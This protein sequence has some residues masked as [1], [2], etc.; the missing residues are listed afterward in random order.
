MGKAVKQA[1]FGGL[2][3][4]VSFIPGVGPVF[5]KFLLTLGMSFVTG[6]LAQA[7]APKP[8]RPRPQYD[9]QYSGT[10]EPRAIIYGQ[11]KTSGMNV[12]PHW[13]SGDGN[14]Y[15]HQVIAIAGHEVEDITD[16]YFNQDVI[17]DADIGAITGALD[18]G[19][20]GGSGDY[21]EVAWIRR[22]LGTSGQTADYIL[23]TAFTAWTSNHRGRG[24]AYVATQFEV[25]EDAYKSGQP[26]QSFIV[27]GKK[28]YDPA[29]DTSPGADPTNASYITYTTNPA[30]ILADYLTD[31]NVGCK[32]PTAKIDWDLVL[33][34]A[35]ICDEDVLIPPASP[36]T[37]QKRYTCNVR[38]FVASTPAERRENILLLAGAMMGYCNFQGGKYR[39]YAGAAQSSDYTLTDDDLVGG[40]SVVTELSADKKYNYVPGQFYDASRNYQLLPFEPRSSSTYETNDGGRKEREVEFPACTAQYEAQR[41]AIT[42][43]KRSRRK[44]EISGLWGFSAYKVRPGK[45]G[46]ITL[47]EWGIV[48]QLVRCQS[49][50]MLPNF[51]F[52]VSFIDEL[53]SDWDDPAV[54]DY[55]VPT[56]AVG[57][58]HGDFV[59]AAPQSFAAI[60]VQDGIL[61]QWEPPANATVGTLYTIFE[62]TSATPFSSA[63]A[64]AS[65]LTGTSRTVIKSDTTTRYY[66]ITAKARRFGTDSDPAPAGDGLPAAALAITTGFRLIAD[67]QTH[68]KV[69]IG[70]GTGS[71]DDT[72]TVTPIDAAAA[73]TYTWTRI[74]GS[75]KLEAISASSAT[76]GFRVVAA[77]P[78][79]DQ[80]EVSAVFECEG[81][82]GTDTATLQVTV[83][84]LRDDSFGS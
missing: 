59:P 37:E 24:V 38:I 27:K 23:D 66:W 80:E 28:C 8:K 5:S 40:V 26:Q 51:T 12:I 76:T 74:S 53:A 2:A 17:A 55:T 78:L 81:D 7:L 42:I 41:N 61:F 70:T 32:I 62:Y 14:K 15:L 34:A 1:V 79:S 60:P 43:L 31:T 57:P 67:R 58:T 21:A 54:G 4:A 39:M 84:I 19:E 48:N 83:T 77:T 73:V 29:L 16:V 49:W 69:L 45:V 72:T 18:D 20:V 64:V 22:Y 25:D 9:V 63:T 36:T 33:A 10:V 47:N 46:T 35:N 50:K 13:P 44:L 11:I 71:T 68:F 56:S 82:D 52:E 65:N 75:T 30:R 6:A 3:I